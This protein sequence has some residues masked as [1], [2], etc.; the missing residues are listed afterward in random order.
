V[1][2]VLV[3]VRVVAHFHL[4]FLAFLHVLAVLALVITGRVFVVV[5]ASAATFRVLLEKESHA[6]SKEL[7]GY[8]VFFGRFAT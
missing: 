1:D 5:G 6:T 2:V 8:G 4:V 7:E 3:V